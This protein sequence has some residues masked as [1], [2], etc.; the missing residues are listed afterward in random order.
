MAGIM[1]SILV[2]VPSIREPIQPS[3][4]FAKKG[5]A[6]HKLDIMGLCGFGCTYCSSNSGNYLRINR[7]RF[8]KAA[9][10][11]TGSPL[12]PSDSPELSIVWSDFPERLHAQLA[13]KEVDWGKGQT[14]VYSMLTDAFSPEM[15]RRG[16]TRWAIEEVLS[17]TSFRVRVLTK[18]SIVGARPWTEFLSQHRQRVVIGL[19]IGSPRAELSQYVEL[20]TSV[21]EAR[22]RAT[23]ALQDAGVTTFGMLCPVFPSA[24]QNGGVEELLER[25]RPAQMERV[26]SEPFNDRKNWQH[27]HDRLPNGHPDKL[28]LRRC[29]GE[30]DHELWSEHA[31][32][33]YQRIRSVAQRGGWLEKFTYLLYESNLTRTGADILGDLECVLLQSKPSDD[34]L[35]ANEHVRALQVA[36][37]EHVSSVLEA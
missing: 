30:R 17:R 3:P 4:G 22:I 27:V 33:L 25:L 28:W 18:N 10:Q 14:L 24:L 16:W 21:P 7:A 2:E 19:S 11:Q 13:P 20:G 5:L 9:W 6:D 37:T 12:T 32:K 35:S 31:A 36:R 29:F 1:K 15:L 34:G 8:R 26:W 23:R